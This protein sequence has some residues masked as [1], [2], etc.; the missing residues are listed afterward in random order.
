[1]CWTTGLHK[2][3]GVGPKVGEVVTRLVGSTFDQITKLGDEVLVEL[4]NALSAPW[5]DEQAATFLDRL[6]ERLQATGHDLSGPDLGRWVRAHPN[7]A[8]AVIECA[9][10]VPPPDVSIISRLSRKGSQ[11]RVF[12][13]NWRQ[14][15]REVVLKQLLGER[16]EQES[17]LGRELQSHP[18]AMRHPNVIATLP[19]TNSRG[20]KFL[21]EEELPEVLKD[22]WRAHGLQEAANLLHDIAR[23]LAYLHGELRLVHG[24]IK[25]DNIGWKSGAYILLDFGICRRDCEFS[26]DATATGSLR[27]RGP[28]LFLTDRYDEPGKADVWSLGATVFNAVTGRF[29]FIDDGEAIPRVSD[30]PKRGAFEEVVKGRIEKEWHKRVTLNEVPEPLRGV[31]TRVLTCDPAERVSAKELVRLCGR[32]LAGFLRSSVGESLAADVELDQ[33][34]RHLPR[35]ATLRAMPTGR[36]R[37]LAERL[38]FLTQTL[39]PDGDKQRVIDELLQALE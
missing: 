2:L 37:Q 6:Q 17:V 38:R 18:L 31:L 35:G 34:L 1:M 32:R 30:P 23:A 22:E 9:L 5:T 20:D 25:P 14:G 8:D 39:H 7:E 13:A 28:E 27:T 12:R 36:K 3:A 21:V 16:A 29:P 33:L 19:L 11:K 10:L 4:A 24:D 15:N 26:R